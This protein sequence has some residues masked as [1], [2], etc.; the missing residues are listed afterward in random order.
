[1]LTTPD[2]VEVVQTAADAAAM[3]IPPL[4]VIDAVIEFM[5]RSALGAGPLS[6]ERIGDGQSNVTY[7]L[8]RDGE[9]FVLRRGPRPPIPRSTH[10]MGR[11][12]RI[13]RML[14]ARGVPVPGVLAASDDTVL[15]V[16]FYIMNYLDGEIITD[17]IPPFL[18]APAERRAT[19]AA[20][21]DAL[22]ALHRV[23][24]SEGDIAELGRPEGY[25][26]RQVERFSALWGPST[27]RELPDVQRIAGW[28]LDHLPEQQRPTVV[29]GDYRIGNLMFARD[30]PAR[31]SAI[32]DWEMAT[33]GDPLADLGY[34]TAT[35]SQGEA[36][37]NPLELT[38]VT[39]QRG[40]LS[41]DEVADR[42]AD[43]MG[44]SLANLPWYQTLA[45]WKAA[46]FCEDIYSRW[47]RGERPD[48]ND[49][50]P[51]LKSGVPLLLDESRRFAGLASR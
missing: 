50:A 7:L 10:D 6:W 43:E 15:G 23:D 9:P 1:M 12:E 42:Y 39:R 29:H 13:L 4:L 2:G 11:E 28:L 17:R 21:V 38:T 40:Y 19:S 46:I 16:P 51:T 32:L 18:D 27:T 35:Y 22:V 47:L 5:D 20:A 33:L 41:R 3:G 31:V 49:F 37:P 48:D 14:G 26:R 25:L 30:A 45:L 36:A 24:A 44:F 8:E 34:L